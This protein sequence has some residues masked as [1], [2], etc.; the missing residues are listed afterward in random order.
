MLQLIDASVAVKSPPW[1]SV[2]DRA[3]AVKPCPEITE[4]DT[5]PTVC[6]PPGFTILEAS[7]AEKIPHGLNAHVTKTVVM[8]SPG[9]VLR[10]QNLQLSQPLDLLQLL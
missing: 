4:P 7:T 10:V 8:L 6:P 3:P 9:F 2:P 1:D 5:I